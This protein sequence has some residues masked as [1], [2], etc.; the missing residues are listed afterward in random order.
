[1][2]TT[3]SVV[4]LGDHA[5]GQRAD[6]LA[7]TAAQH[8]ATIIEIHTF[9]P[10]DAISHDDLALV[11]AVVKALSRAIGTNA[12]IWVPFPVEDFGREQH[13]RRLSLVLQRHGLNLLFGQCLTPCPS[14]GGMNEMDFAL[15]REVQT[16]DDLDNAALAAA[17]FHTLREEIELAL[18]AACTTEPIG[19]PAHLQPVQQVTEMLGQLELKCGPR[20]TLP[21]PTMAWPERQPA[22]K[23]YATW[24][25]DRC[26]LTQTEAANLINAAGHRTPHGRMWQ[27]AT[28]S[29]LI[30]GRYDRPAAA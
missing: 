15:R 29:A 28:V 22:L 4:V 12:H 18:T 24:L 10:G 26:G 23:R 2:F 8:G 3:C 6:V 16:V 30:H 25:V 14:T 7:E 20:P 21:E 11:D 13:F 27:Q 5:T 1:M 19:S 17:G 9:E